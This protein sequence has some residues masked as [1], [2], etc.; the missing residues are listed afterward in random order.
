MHPESKSNYDYVKILLNDGKVWAVW[1]DDISSIYDYDKTVADIQA[2]Y[3][4]ATPRESLFEVVANGQRKG[5]GT[6]GINGVPLFLGQCA[7]P[8]L[9][10]GGAGGSDSITLEPGC[11]K[12]LWMNY[13]LTK[14][15]GL[16]SIGA[17]NAQLVDLD[18]GRE[19]FAS[20][21]GAAAAGAAADVKRG[22]P[23]KL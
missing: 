5:D 9:W 20:M 23:A 18:G 14:T 12:V 4:E 8:P 19:F 16:K 7:I 17:G 2:K 3:P 22:G 10:N 15:E 11:N 6:K 13:A 1:R 21:R